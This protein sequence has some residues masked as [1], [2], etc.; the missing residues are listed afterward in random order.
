MQHGV[1]CQSY[2]QNLLR[3]DIAKEQSNN[4]PYANGNILQWALCQCHF[5]LQKPVCS[6]VRPAR[7]IM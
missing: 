5:Y 4:R 2:Y 7:V 1:I 6:A 3:S